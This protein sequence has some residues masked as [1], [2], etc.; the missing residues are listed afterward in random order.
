M[1][2]KAGNIFSYAALLCTS[3][4]FQNAAIAEKQD[5]YMGAP[6]TLV[7]DHP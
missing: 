5:I 1:N 3:A 4:L 2:K 7:Q 6:V